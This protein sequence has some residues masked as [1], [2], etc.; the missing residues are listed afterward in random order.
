MSATDELR[1]ELTRLGI[2]YE[3]NEDNACTTRVRM[4]GKLFEF[5]ELG[6]RFS[7]MT[8][9]P[10]FSQQ[11]DGASALT[12]DEAI[13]ATVGKAVCQ[14]VYHPKRTRS[15]GPQYTCS[16]CGYGASDYRWSYCPKCGRKYLRQEATL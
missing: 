8:L 10:D 4:D 9:L 13:E 7:T 3:S 11:G 14:R 16:A 12:V 2:D 6:E 15:S 1:A 5:Y